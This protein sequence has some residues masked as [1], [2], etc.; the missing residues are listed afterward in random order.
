MS[1][2]PRFKG[3]KSKSASLNERAAWFASLRGA[4]EPVA[5]AVGGRESPFAAEP[6][7]VDWAA[8]RKAV[9]AEE[10]GLAVE[11][12]L[13]RCREMAKG[14]D[15]HRRELIQE[16]V[17]KSCELL[18]TMGQFEAAL[19]CAEEKGPDIDPWP[20]LARL[21]MDAARE[22]RAGW[23]SGWNFAQKAQSLASSH[24][25]GSIESR[26]GRFLDG[27]WEP[28]WAEVARFCVKAGPGQRQD[29]ARLLEVFGDRLDAPLGAEEDFW[30]R[31][32]GEI[33]EAVGDAGLARELWDQT[34]LYFKAAWTSAAKPSS[35]AS[36]EALE[37]MFEL[38]EG[39]EGESLDQVGARVCA[40]V[41][42]SLD[43]EKIKALLGR[44][45]AEEPGWS[46]AGLRGAD[47]HIMNGARQAWSGAVSAWAR[48][49]GGFEGLEG[50]ADRLRARL[51]SDDL[52][53]ASAKAPKGPS[54]RL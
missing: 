3:A 33:S 8:P 34:P 7:E 54:P 38:L 12:A 14:A 27:H 45:E 51:L 31:L 25:W 30:T 46:A 47:R 17:A 19:A 16:M 10:L 42:S 53:E 22:A 43:Q 50:M 32:A 2:G 11:A 13:S 20:C 24:A 44:F 18:A 52:D 29:A 28:A 26:A 15:G 5:L 35:K 23:E 1:K 49:E 6:W 48:D 39:L 21:A 4:W 40:C 41:W 9:D 36:R 37:W